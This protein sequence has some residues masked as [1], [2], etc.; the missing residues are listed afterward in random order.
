MPN[1]LATP[2]GN[3]IWTILLRG[4]EI[5][6]N[7]AHWSAMFVGISKCDF[8]TPCTV[9]NC[10]TVRILANNIC[11]LNKV[12]VVIV[13]CRPAARRNSN[14]EH[15]HCCSRKAIWLHFT[16]HLAMCKLTK[17]LP[18]WKRLCLQCSTSVYP[19]KTWE[20]IDLKV[21]SSNYSKHAITKIK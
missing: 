12:W 8:F 6:C 1:L 2:G 21:G 15:Y 5:S 13:W 17:N 14:C 9:F 10:N 16:S 18:D 11:T 20:G 4:P 19:I 7:F 3:Y